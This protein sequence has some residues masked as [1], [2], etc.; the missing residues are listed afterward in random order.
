MRPAV[1]NVR[2]V[3]KATIPSAGSTPCPSTKATASQSLAVPSVNAATSTMRPMSSVRG[4]VQAERLAGFD[5][6][7][8]SSPWVGR[9]RAVPHITAM[10]ESTEIAATCTSME[11]SSFTKPAPSSAAATVPPLKAAW[12]HGMIAF[13]RPSS[14]RV[15]S[16]F[17][18]TSQMP[19]PSPKRNSPGLTHMGE[20]PNCTARAASSAPGTVS[21]RPR[22]TVAAA[23]IW[24]AIRPAVGRPM[25]AP[26]DSASSSTP[27]WP[28]VSASAALTSGMRDIQ[29]ANRTPLMAN[30][31]RS[32]LRA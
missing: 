13:F 24:C 8:A 28:G 7:P 1:M 20:A 12:N 14:M 25:S 19:L 30:T 11:T 3:A 5:T 23:P 22:R 6:A 16:R 2:K 18:A 27:S 17:W 15:P 32:P 29:V 31:T 10:T 21:S 9:K 4:S 26:T